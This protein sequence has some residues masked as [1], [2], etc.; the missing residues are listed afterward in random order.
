MRCPVCL[1]EGTLDDHGVDL[2]I[3]GDGL[4]GSWASGQRTCPNPS[5]RALLFVVYG[6][7]SRE[8]KASFP[9][10]RLDFD[11]SDLPE[12][13]REPLEE[14]IEC[15][16]QGCYKAAAVMVRRALEAVCVDQ[17][18]TGD[19]LKQRIQDLGAKIV[20]PKG[21]IDSLQD[22]RLLG[23]DAAHVEAKDYDDV[24]VAEVEIAVEITKVIVQ[25][26]FQM[27]AILGGLKSLK[28]TAPDAGG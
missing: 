27:D 24:G 12:G 6:R 9:P 20:L 8:V 15:H 21:F 19:N 25:A 14:A 23:N 4:D 1:H 3:L 28:R 22:L 26:T 17:N 10:E 2:M 11:A 7:S 5:C 18:A 13:V 16:A